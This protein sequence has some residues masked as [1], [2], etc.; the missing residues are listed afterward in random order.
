MGAVPLLWDRWK[1]VAGWRPRLEAAALLEAAGGATEL[2]LDLKGTSRLLPQMVLRA[3]EDSIPGRPVTVCSRNWRLLEPFRYQPHVRVI[4]SVGSQGQLA[5]VPRH[6]TGHGD[7][8]L[9]I[10]QRLLS[11]A[12]VRALKQIAPTIITW[13]VNTEARMQELIAWG[14]DGVISDDLALLR[15]L[16]ATRQDAAMTEQPHE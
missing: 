4:H 15:R 11:P 16:I 14:V 3:V 1:L 9:S 13:P 7:H 12:T 6:L 10:H 8:A 5:A 2:M